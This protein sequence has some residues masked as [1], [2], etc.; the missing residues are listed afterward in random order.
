MFE[1]LFYF[2]GAESIFVMYSECYNKS[3]VWLEF[4][5]VQYFK[6]LS[7]FSCTS[8]LWIDR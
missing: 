6:V 7:L 5:A 1:S 3:L 2:L 8:L 4:K